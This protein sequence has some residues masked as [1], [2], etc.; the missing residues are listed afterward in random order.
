LH[1]GWEIH[2]GTVLH[3]YA[4]RTHGGPY[5]G[6]LSCPPR[7]TENGADAS[8]G[9]GVNGDGARRLRLAALTLSLKEAGAQE[10]GGK[11]LAG[12]I[13]EDDFIELQL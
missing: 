6:A 4:D 13:R 7:P 12:A 11:G 3:E 2:V 10:I 5:R 9:G 1:A 8:A